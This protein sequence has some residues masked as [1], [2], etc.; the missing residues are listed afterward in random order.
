MEKLTEKDFIEIY[1]GKEH[2]E[3]EVEK[4]YW[5]KKLKGDK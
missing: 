3:A 4:D 2:N 1:K 5:S